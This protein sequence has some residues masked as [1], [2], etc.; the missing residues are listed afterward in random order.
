[1]TNQS[2]ERLSIHMEDSMDIIKETF[3]IYWSENKYTPELSRFVLFTSKD[4]SQYG[5]VYVK[6]VE[7]EVEAPTD[8]DPRAAKLASLREEEKR[9]RAE[10]QARITEL[11]RQQSE[12]LAIE[13]VEAA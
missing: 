12:L 1:M 3:H 9:V 7:I 13:M 5:Y 4:M 6:P 8:F 11:Q 2:K 10:F